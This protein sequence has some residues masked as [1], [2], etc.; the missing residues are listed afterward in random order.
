MPHFVPE[1]WTVRYW[2]VGK[3]PA[4]NLYKDNATEPMFYGFD[5]LINGR[6]EKRGGYKAEGFSV[7][8]FEDQKHMTQTHLVLLA[9][10]HVPGYAG[11][12][13]DTINAHQLIT[14]RFGS[15]AEPQEAQNKIVATVAKRDLEQKRLF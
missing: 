3:A 5:T 9:N 10:N 6:W 12:I 7:Y 13:Y 2:V 14:V 11:W 15:S 4:G 8:V 1:D